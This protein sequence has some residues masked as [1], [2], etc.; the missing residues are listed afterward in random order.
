[1][2]D[3]ALEAL[4]KFDFGTPLEDVSEIEV[5]V[6]EAHTKPESRK[7]LE[8]KLIAALD[9]GLTRDGKDYVCRKLALIGTSASV[10]AL[11]ALI[12][13]EEN[14]HLARHALERIPGAEAAKAF[15]DAIAK[16]SGKLKVGL[17]GSLALR[18]DQATI[19]TLASLLQNTD[20]TIARAAALALGTMGGS[21]AVRTLQDALGSTN[22]DKTFLIDALLSCAESMLASRQTSEAVAIYKSLSADSQSRL[23]RLAATRG[24]LAC[25]NA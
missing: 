11:S 21:E 19:G 15:Q 9:T 18:R 23:V 10:P 5:A 22:S 3:Q 24:L 25:A 16:T 12:S 14:S 8:G 13:S 6:I 4:K 7:E 20:A 2:L 1:M 17:I